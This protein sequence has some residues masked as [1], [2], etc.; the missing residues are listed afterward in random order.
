[1]L[2]SIRME[3]K[4]LFSGYFRI[5]NKL[6]KAVKYIF[7]IE[8]NDDDISKMATDE[9]VRLQTNLNSMDIEVNTD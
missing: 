5:S 1:M 3:I 9:L 4:N 6:M 8:I 2:L 7:Y